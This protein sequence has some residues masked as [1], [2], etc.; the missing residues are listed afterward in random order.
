M[1]YIARTEFMKAKADELKHIEW[2]ADCQLFSLSY[3]PA[4]Y[5]KALVQGFFTQ[6]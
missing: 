1:H 5:N 6:V 4:K 3:K 2:L